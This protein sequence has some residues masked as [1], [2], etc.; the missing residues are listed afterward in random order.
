MI[1]IPPYQILAQQPSACAYVEYT[2]LDTSEN[3]APAISGQWTFQSVQLKY[4]PEE[5]C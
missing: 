1:R 5:T 4:I 3:P 2:M